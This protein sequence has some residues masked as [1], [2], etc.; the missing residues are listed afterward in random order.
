MN[1]NENQP[2]PVPD[3]PNPVLNNEEIVDPT[4][5]AGN[6]EVVVIKRHPFGL[7]AL[8]LQVIVGLGVAAGLIDFLVNQ[9]ISADNRASILPWL[10]L[11]LILIAGI[12]VIFLIIA[13]FV[14]LQNRWIVTD[15]SITQITQNGLFK[16]Q[17][18][19]LSMAN[20]EDVT[21]VQ[22]GLLATVFGFGTLKAETAGERSN[23]HFIYC[24]R[25]N[26]Y[27]KI[28]LDARERFINENPDVA[29]R[30]NDLLNVP[31]T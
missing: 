24:P 11:V 21:A 4:I 27:A 28:V 14:Y 12:A 7:V 25:P 9:L 16:R 6:H 15:D 8:Y 10:N 22:N 26:T 5:P 1:P 29:K 2:E 31:R 17:M 20:I 13:T 23:F 18:S 3:V 30:A 19:E